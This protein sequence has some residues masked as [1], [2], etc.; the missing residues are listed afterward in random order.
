MAKIYKTNGEIIET[1]PKNGI[2]FSLEELQGVVGGYVEIVYLS[3]ELI[4]VLNE[5]GKISELPFNELATELYQDS[6]SIHDYIVGDVL[7]CD[8]KQVK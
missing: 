2:D 8:K 7:V 1:E 4:M 6:I 5:E 3:K